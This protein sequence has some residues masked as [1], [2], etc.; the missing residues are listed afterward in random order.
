MKELDNLGLDPGSHNSEKWK[1]YSKNRP[2]LVRTSVWPM[3][4]EFFWPGYHPSKS[5]QLKTL[6][7]FYDK[8]PKRK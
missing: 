4:I 2:T 5:S 6:E 1:S 7:H 3:V 8:N